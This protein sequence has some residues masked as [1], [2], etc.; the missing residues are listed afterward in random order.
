MITYLVRGWLLGIAT[1]TT[2]LSTCL[3]VYLPYLLTEERTGKQSF[4]IVLEITIGRFLSYIAF[5]AIF[6]FV[7]S[8]LPV[9]SRSFFTSLAYVLLSIYLV[10]SFFRIHRNSRHCRN[11]MWMQLTRNPFLLG[12]LTGISFCPAFLIAVSNAIEISGVLSGISLF[13]GFFLGTSLFIIPISFL[14]ALS[15]ITNLRKIALAASILVAIFFFYK[16]IS[17]LIQFQ[18]V[19]IQENNAS[20]S[21]L[22][23]ESF[24]AGDSLFIYAHSFGEKWQML[25]DVLLAKGYCVHIM[26][27]EED[28]DRIPD[29]AALFSHLP[30][31]RISELQVKQAWKVIWLDISNFNSKEDFQQL[32]LFLENVYFRFNPVEGFEFTVRNPPQNQFQN[33]RGD[34]D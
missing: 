24:L 22:T 34:N 33:Q 28:L 14:G 5:G 32:N 10:I 21:L 18:Q 12:I 20:D 30:D 23:A 9:E 6:G 2:C 15:R 17:G 25:S 13:A 26:N 31:H 1:G 7:G 16:G 11:L 19:R 29:G 8:R 3:P 4:R 27:S